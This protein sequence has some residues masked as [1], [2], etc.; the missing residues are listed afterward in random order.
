MRP[1][2]IRLFATLTLASAAVLTHG[3]QVVLPESVNLDLRGTSWVLTQAITADGRRISLPAVATPVERRNI[4]GSAPMY[5][6]EFSA[7]SDT[8]V[9]TYNCT[10]ALFSYKIQTDTLILRPI[11]AI[12]TIGC[13]DYSYDDYARWLFESPV[14]RY[15]VN[16]GVLVLHYSTGRLVYRRVDRVYL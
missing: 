11:G 16:E 14:V 8:L 12:A 5:S 10:G 4:P 1:I 15:T 2:I 6:F 13:R 3:C 7:Q 9:T